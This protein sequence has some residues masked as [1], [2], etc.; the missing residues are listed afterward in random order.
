MATLNFDESIVLILFAQSIGTNPTQADIVSFDARLQKDFGSRL[1][2]TMTA[3]G[4]EIDVH[5]RSLV[6]GCRPH[7]AGNTPAAQIRNACRYVL[8]AQQALITPLAVPGPI[9]AVGAAAPAALGRRKATRA[10]RPV[11][12]R[13]TKSSRSV[14]RAKPRVSARGTRHRR[15]RAP[16]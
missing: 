15:V 5:S 6:L 12:R 11:S 14:K 9:A 4:L 16:K 10:A 7:M 13:T 3:E 2:E 8:K 1:Q